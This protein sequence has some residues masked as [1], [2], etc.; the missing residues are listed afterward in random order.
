M[1]HALERPLRRRPRTTSGDGLVHPV[2]HLENVPLRTLVL[3]DRHAF[4]PLATCPAPNRLPRGR[5]TAAVSGSASRRLRRSPL[6]RVLPRLADGLAAARGR[7]ARALRRPRLAAASSS[8]PSTASAAARRSTSCSRGRSLTPA[9]G[10]S[11]CASS[12][13]SSR[14]ASVPVVALLGARLAGRHRGARGDRVVCGRAGCC[15]STASTRACTAS[16]S[17]RARS[18]TWRCSPRP[19]V[20][21]RRAWALWAL[22]ILACDRD[23]IRTA[24]SCSRRRVST[25]SHARVRLREARARVRGRRGRRDPVLVR[26][27]SCSRAASTSG[28][29]GG[30]GEAAAARSTCSTTSL[31]ARGRLHR[32]A[33]ALARS[34]SCSLLAAFGLVVLARDGAAR[35]SSACVFADADRDLPRRRARAARPSPESR[36]LIFALPVLRALLASALVRLCAARP[37]AARRRSCVVARVAVELA[38]AHA[39]HA[40]ALR[41]RA[42]VA[43][44]ARETASRWLAATSPAETTSCSA[45]T[46]SSSAPGSDGGDVSRTVVPRA[47][48]ALALT[49][50]RDARSRSAAASVVFDAS[51]TNNWRQRLYVGALSPLPPRRLRGALL[52][53]VPRRAHGRADP[54]RR[55]ASSRARARQSCSA[56]A[57]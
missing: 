28:V 54:H 51:D 57:C 55:P 23:A 16:S 6:A 22:A 24:R 13:R 48:A 2:E 40:A 1:Q 36:H 44:A 46:R 8:T 5:T 21:G 3:V 35:C 9:A 53:P 30:G 18:R 19:S 20:A 15:S 7:D 33:G 14:S 27:T 39:P 10:W 50:L 12:R 37:A 41:R 17:S 52:G 26:S 43:R 31:H 25:C 49:V 29:G 38:W 45:T 11:R 56:R 32:R 34:C 42:A 4:T 47:D